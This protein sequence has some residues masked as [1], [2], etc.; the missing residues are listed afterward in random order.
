MCKPK[1][2]ND[3]AAQIQLVT[4]TALEADPAP[5]LDPVFE[6]DDEP[7]DDEL[8]DDE[9]VDDE[10]VAE[11]L[12][13]PSALEELPVIA[14]VASPALDAVPLDVEL[15]ELVFPEIAP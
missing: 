4:Y 7:V 13:E 3:R 5:V 15:F 6:P 10:P 2:L 9:L 11:E 8:A 12:E 1:K 14:F